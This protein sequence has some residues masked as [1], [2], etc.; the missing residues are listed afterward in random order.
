M[1][2]KHKG[3]VVEGYVQDDGSIRSKNGKTFYGFSEKGLVE[4]VEVHKDAPEDKDA[5]EAD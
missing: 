3:K 1:K 4:G 2:L 5:K